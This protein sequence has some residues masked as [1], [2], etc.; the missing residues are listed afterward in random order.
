MG[1]R[2]CVL[3]KPPLSSFSWN[4]SVH[5]LLVILEK[6]EAFKPQDSCWPLFMDMPISP[7]TAVQH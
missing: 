2:E 7:K 3:V 1:T 4:H 5:N 6:R